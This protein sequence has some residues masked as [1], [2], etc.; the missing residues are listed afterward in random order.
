MHHC[1]LKILHQTFTMKKGLSDTTYN[2]V[3]WYIH[4]NIVQSIK[5]NNNLDLFK[6]HKTLH[7]SSTEHSADAVVPIYLDKYHTLPLTRNLNNII[8]KKLI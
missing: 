6:S 5:N 4:K 1:C 3:S 2:I 7:L 8:N